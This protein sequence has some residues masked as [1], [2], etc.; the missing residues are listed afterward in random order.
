MKLAIDTIKEYDL[1][2]DAA[3]EKKENDFSLALIV[4]ESTN[5]IRAKELGENF[6]RLLKSLIPSSIEPNSSKDIG[7][8]NYNYLIGVYGN[9]TN[10]KICM[11]AK[12]SSAR[13]ITW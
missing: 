1:V 7:S 13:K 9:T 2:S 12:A 11:G 6:V 10:N 4:N 3:I 5:S 8:G